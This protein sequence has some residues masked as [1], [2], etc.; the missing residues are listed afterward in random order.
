MVIVICSKRW[1]LCRRQLM[2]IRKRK[3][4]GTRGS[5]QSSVTG[6]YLMGWAT[7]YGG[8]FIVGCPWLVVGLV[9]Q[10]LPAVE[11]RR[12]V[13]R[14]VVGRFFVMICA[15]ETPTFWGWGSFGYTPP[16]S[17]DRYGIVAAK[18]L[19]IFRAHA[20]RA[21]TPEHEKSSPLMKHKI[22]KKILCYWN[23]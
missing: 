3:I 16:K 22:Q 10:W 20:W 12:W 13:R 21:P 2:I 23:Q 5:W 9:G 15:A 7:I 14:T 18:I 4:V 11:S 17:S 8:C 19:E 1:K 6:I